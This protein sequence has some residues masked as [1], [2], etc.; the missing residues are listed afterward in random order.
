MISKS[1]AKAGRALAILVASAALVAQLEAIGHS[2]SDLFRRGADLVTQ[3]SVDVDLCALCL[4]AFHS[5]TNP[6]ALPAVPRPDVESQSRPAK[7]SLRYP[8]LR[9]VCAP[10]RAPPRLSV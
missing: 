4:L 2:H 3:A 1:A 5:P 8:T 7:Q 6:G 9:L 10:M